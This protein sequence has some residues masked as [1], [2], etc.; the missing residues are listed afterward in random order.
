M[1]H[2]IFPPSRRGSHVKSDY[3]RTKKGKVSLAG[4][5]PMENL[6]PQFCGVNYQLLVVMLNPID[7]PLPPTL[8]RAVPPER[9]Q[10]TV[11]INRLCQPGTRTRDFYMRGNHPACAATQGIR[12]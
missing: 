5:P 10:R 3:T 12:N 8:H 9:H 6:L 4:S 2:E 11:H 7:W 1:F